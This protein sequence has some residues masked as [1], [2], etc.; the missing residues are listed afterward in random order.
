[1]ID[2]ISNQNVSNSTRVT[3]IEKVN[4]IQKLEDVLVSHEKRENEEPSSPIQKEKIEEVVK[5]INDFIQPI[6][7]S[8][9]FVLH[10]KLN[11]YYVKVVDN[12]TDEVIK[13]I[14]TK[15]LMDTYAAMMEFVGLLVDKKV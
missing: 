4:P 10:D 3:S 6:N 8:I 11:E 13:E 5:G 12:Q 14:P 7:T 1:M 2:R 9:Q 15:K